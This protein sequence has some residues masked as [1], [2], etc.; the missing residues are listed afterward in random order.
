MILKSKI[1]WREIGTIFENTDLGQCC[2]NRI[3]YGQQTQVLR[4]QSA[5]LLI[6][7]GKQQKMAK[8]LE[9]RT[10]TGDPDEAPGSW[11]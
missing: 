4:F 6:R 7:L 2:G 5:F 3:W 9:P 10:H 1:T 8:V 11:L